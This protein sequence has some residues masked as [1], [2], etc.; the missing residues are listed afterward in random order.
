MVS[1]GLETRPEIRSEVIDPPV[2]PLQWETATP[3]QGSGNVLILFLLAL[4]LGLVVRYALPSQLRTTFQGPDVFHW[5]G[6]GTLVAAVFV[7][8]FLHEAGHLSAALLANFEVLA[9]V[10]GPFRAARVNNVWTL[11]FSLRSLF[12]GSV[13][14][15]PRNTH[16]WRQRML[17]VVASGPLATLFTGA[18]AAC[19]LLLHP[20]H[21]WPNTF[22][23]AITQL[24]AFIFVLGLIPNS[25]N[26][27]VRNDARLLLVLSRESDQCRE[28]LMY[29]LLTRLELAGVRPRDYPLHIL[30]ELAHHHGRPDLMLFSAH[31]IVLWALD[32]GFL[33]TALAWDQRCVDLSG[34][35]QPSSRNLALAT[36]A[37]LDVLVRNRLLN[38]Q[39]KFADIDW[40]SLS[41]SWL[42]HR[43]RAAYYLTKG[44]VPDC[45]SEI[46]RARYTFPQH[47]P[48]YAFEC[49]LLSQLHRKALDVQPPD[50]ANC[51]S[52]YAA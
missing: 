45:L 48:S 50:L 9:I 47:L 2:P 19:L 22:I 39:S 42:M 4:S 43:S 7:S 51:L 28:I 20:L 1:S 24:S 18:A 46:A 23:G 29:H 33:A 13:S 11:R 36:S 25:T 37:C 27:R 32:R 10:L 52:K 15:V 12:S 34:A 8:I 3:Q 44:N 21:G 16:A 41:P 26:A 14:A 31:K 35:C 30:R 17:F 38:A 49:T 40:E 6:V 5:V